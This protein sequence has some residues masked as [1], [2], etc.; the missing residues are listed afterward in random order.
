M[1]ICPF[2]NRSADIARKGAPDVVVS[3]FSGEGSHQSSNGDDRTVVAL[4]R[5]VTIHPETL[6][7]MYFA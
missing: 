5:A 7:V 4:A 2:A 1:S 6:K 3:F